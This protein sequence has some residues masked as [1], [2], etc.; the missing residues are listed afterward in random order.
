MVVVGVAV[1]DV[2]AGRVTVGVAI[3]IGVT[4][5]AGSRAGNTVTGGVAVV[6]AGEVVVGVVVRITRMVEELK[7]NQALL[8]GITSFPR[9][10]K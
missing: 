1:M 4:V 10:L 6:V 3:E 5:A 2:V 7:M 8:Q 9:T